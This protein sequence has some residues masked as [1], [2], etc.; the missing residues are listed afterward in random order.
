MK[1]QISTVRERRETWSV[2]DNDT[3]NNQAVCSW[4]DALTILQFSLSVIYYPL[5][6]NIS[7]TLNILH[8]PL[9]DS[10][11]KRERE[12]EEVEN[13]REKE[14]FLNISCLVIIMKQKQV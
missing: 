7:V 9:F 6:N 10:Q 5:W 11:C 12:I 14:V 8:H 13:Y 1:T 3:V 4:R 2:V